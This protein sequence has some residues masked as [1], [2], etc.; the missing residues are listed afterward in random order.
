MQ[1]EGLTLAEAIVKVLMMIVIMMT[2][3]MI[4]MLFLKK[5]I[6]MKQLSILNNMLKELRKGAKGARRLAKRRFPQAADRVGKR[7]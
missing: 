1:H 7:V 3:M 5:N 2:M 6:H 4:M